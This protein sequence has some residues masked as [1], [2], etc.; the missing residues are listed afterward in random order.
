[1]RVKS[2]WH[3][4]KRDGNQNKAKS[5]EE[6]AG[7]LA[8]SCWRIAGNSVVEIEN[9]GYHTATSNDRL[10]IVAE[11]LA[12]LLQVSD[13]L[14]YEKL[15]P[16]QRQTFIPAVALNMA[17]TF[18]DNKT[19]IEGAGEHQQPFID[20]LNQRGES[21]AQCGFVDDEPGFDF[22]RVFGEQVSAVLSK[23]NPLWVSQFV[24]EVNSPEILKTLKQ[25]V[26]QLFQAE[27][28]EA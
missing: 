24:A 18:A 17:H 2:R 21:Y 11:Y 4:T 28:A 14:L 22:L 8:F 27:I 12:F 13:R 15:T 20:L 9:Q 25:A 10:N 3:Q 5:L 16:E 26:K 1:M 6:I 7:A 19:D 23:D